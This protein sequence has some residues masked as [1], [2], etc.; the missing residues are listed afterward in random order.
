MRLR[1][2]IIVACACALLASCGGEKRSAEP[3]DMIEPERGK[4]AEIWLRA[5]DHTEPA[6]WLAR[7]EAGDA[8]SERDPSVERI[9]SALASARAHF[10]E[11][12][13]MLA[14]RTAQVG[15]MLATDGHPEGFAQLISSLVDVAA[16]AGQ[17]QTYGELCQ[18]YY[19]LRHSGIERDAALHMLASRYSTQRQFR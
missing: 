14:N 3:D 15:E 1:G 5:T 11:S 13:R 9:R 6:L 16:S 8:V 12:Y 7:R 10:L 2:A 4:S 19:N 18:H 17:K